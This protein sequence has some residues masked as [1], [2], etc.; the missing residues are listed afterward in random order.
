MINCVNQRRS[1]KKL[2]IYIT[3]SN[4]L[5]FKVCYLLENLIENCNLIHCLVSSS[6]TTLAILWYRYLALHFWQITKSVS[7]WGFGRATMTALIMISLHFSTLHF[8]EVFHHQLLVQCLLSLC[9]F[10]SYFL[11]LGN[12]A[13]LSLA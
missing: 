9:L 13:I 7:E 2:I 10:L 11:Y 12:L 5:F 4:N 1:C 6:K 3:I 8:L